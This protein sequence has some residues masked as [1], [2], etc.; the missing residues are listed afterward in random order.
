MFLPVKDD[1]SWL[2]VP[3]ALLTSPV[4]GESSIGEIFDVNG[5]IAGE[6]GRSIDIQLDTTPHL[7]A[8]LTPSK[9]KSFGSFSDL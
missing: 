7:G 5:R 2:K 3:A 4:G 6:E 8:D 1:F 9:W